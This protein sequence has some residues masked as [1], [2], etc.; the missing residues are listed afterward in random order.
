MHLDVLK[1]R[2]GGV[3]Y[4]HLGALISVTTFYYG[5]PPMCKSG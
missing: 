3:P 4:L 5:S 1:N 2:N